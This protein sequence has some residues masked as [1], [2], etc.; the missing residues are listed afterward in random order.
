MAEQSVRDIRNMTDEQLVDAIEDQR[1]K[2][3][4]LRFQKAANQL[5]DGNQL[6]YAKRG[7]ARLL[8]MQHERALAAQQSAE[9]EK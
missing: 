3:F 1:E 5:E 9:G 6:R 2:I 4:N 7:L 8:G